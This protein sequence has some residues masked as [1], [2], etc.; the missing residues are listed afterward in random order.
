V[1]DID[2]DGEMEIVFEAGPHVHAFNLDGAAVPGFPLEFFQMSKLALAD[3][4]GDGDAEIIVHGQTLPSREAIFLT[5]FDYDT[6]TNQPVVFPGWPLGDF[7]GFV[8]DILAVNI[9]SDAEL[10]VIYTSTAKVQRTVPGG[11]T[12]N[13]FTRNFVT[14]LNHDGTPWNGGW[15]RDFMG[16]SPSIAVGDLNI[17]RNFVP[18]PHQDGTPGNRG[19]KR[20]FMGNSHSIGV[21]HLNIPS[22]ATRGLVITYRKFYAGLDPNGPDWNRVETVLYSFGGTFDDDRMHWSHRYG[23]AQNSMAT[24]GDSDFKLGFQKV[25]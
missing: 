19:W 12:P 9:D 17:P 18:K 6:Q 11:R 1:G 20:D 10:E 2:G 21:G 3:M 5:I 16:H 7:P 4:D 25:R 14:I 22:S 8:G 15:E 24:T 13:I 23:N